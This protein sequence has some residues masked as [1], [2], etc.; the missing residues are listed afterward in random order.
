MYLSP[1]GVKHVRKIGDR[2]LLF[3]LKRPTRVINRGLSPIIPL[4]LIPDSRENHL[5]ILSGLL[6]LLFGR[7]TPVH[8]ETGLLDRFGLIAMI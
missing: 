8:F 4:F 2:P 5:K 7:N 6:I 3:F 1:N